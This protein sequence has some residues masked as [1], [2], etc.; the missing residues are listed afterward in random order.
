MPPVNWASCKRA[1][2]VPLPAFAWRKSKQVALANTS[3]SPIWSTMQ[4]WQCGNE[5][6]QPLLLALLAPLEQLVLEQDSS[7]HAGT[8][9]K[10]N[11][12]LPVCQT[13]LHMPNKVA[14]CQF[15]EIWTMLRF[16]I[17]GD[18]KAQKFCLNLFRNLEGI[19][20]HYRGL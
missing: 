17:Y 13:C 18:I 5:Q 20:V 8:W 9:Q 1:S 19:V 12:I 15:L 7:R 6:E 2:P 16:Q 10:D 4:K 14:I 3:D 11:V